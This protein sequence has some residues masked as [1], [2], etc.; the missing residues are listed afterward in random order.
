MSYKT[1]LK[2]AR[3]AVRFEQ[4]TASLQLVLQEVGTCGLAAIQKY[5]AAGKPDFQACEA[6]GF[7]F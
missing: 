5:L 1:Y 2:Y 7:S 6:A 3:L 4:G